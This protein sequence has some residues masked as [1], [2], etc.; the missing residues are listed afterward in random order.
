MQSES[1]ESQKGGQLKRH[2]VLKFLYVDKY[3]M[4]KCKITFCTETGDKQENS[5]HT[6]SVTNAKQT[7]KHCPW[8][9]ALARHQMI[10][11]SIYY[12]RS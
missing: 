1:S 5:A 7:Q 9:T 12:K 3:E 4:W 11:D 2:T 8:K 6:S 10:H